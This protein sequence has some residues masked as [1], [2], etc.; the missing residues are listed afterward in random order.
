[1]NKLQ[2]LQFSC[3]KIELYLENN[4]AAGNFRAKSREGKLLKGYLTCPDPRLKI[5]PVKFQGEE[6]EI[7]LSFEGRGPKQKEAVEGILTFISN[8]GEAEISYVIR[9]REVRLESSLGEIR[10]LFHFTNLAR[11]SWEEAVNLFFS[12]EFSELLESARGEEKELYRGLK[13]TGSEQCVEEFLLAI[14]KK[15]PV[16]YHLEKEI[17]TFENME[18]DQKEEIRIDREGWGYTKLR[19]KK[20]GDFLSLEKDVLEESDFLGNSC[21]LPVYF[22]VDRL[23]R[24]KNYGA[25]FLE[26]AYGSMT[27]RIEVNQNQHH[28]MR[29]AIEKRR[30]IK[31]MKVQLTELYV[32]FRAKRIAASR[33]RK[34]TEQILGKMRFTDERNPQGKL[35]MAH[36]YI[37]TDKRL[38]GKWH[39][40]RVG[41]MIQ[42]D[43]DPVAYAYYLYLNTLLN[44][45]VEYQEKVRE[46]VEELYYQNESSWQIAWLML[47]LSREFHGGSIVSSSDTVNSVMKKWDFLLEVFRAGCTSPVLYTEAVM[48]LNFQPTLL[49]ELGSLELRILRFGQSRCMLSEEV[50]GIVQYLSLREKEYSEGLFR[51]LES[52]CLTEDNPEMLQS[53]CSLLIKGNKKENRYFPWYE[54]AVLE[55]LKI[56]RLYEYYM[57]SLDRSKKIDIPRMVLLYFSYE[58]SLSYPNAAYLYRYVHEQRE[59]ME[60]LYLAYAPRIERFMVKQLYS[61]KINRDLGYLYEHLLVPDM[62]TP[63]NASALEKI[64]FIHSFYGKEEADE[65]LIAVH[66]HLKEETRG[67]FYQGRARLPL[68]GKNYLLFRENR[69]GERFLVKEEEHPSAFVDLDSLSKC[70]GTYTCDDLGLALYCCEEKGG[71]QPVREENEEHF[72]FLSEYPEVKEE[73]KQ[74][75]RSRLMDYYEE[76]DRM[77]ELDNWLENCTPDALDRKEREK[78]ID[79]MIARGYYEKAYHFVLVYGPEQV[80]PKSLVRIGTY[81]LEEDTEEK[82]DLLWLMDTAWQKGKYNPALLNFLAEN[83]RGGCRQMAALF[84]AAKEFDGEVY[85]LSERI[86]AQILFSGTNVKEDV[87]IFKAYVAE[88]AKT[89]LE[90]A[91]LTWCA[92][93][94]LADRREMDGYFIRDILRVY[95]RSER[96]HPIT[97]LACLKY[98]A[99]F[100]EEKKPE[101]EE[102]IRDFLW[103]ALRRKEWHFPFL[104]A[105]K[106]YPEM[107]ILSD[108]SILF[109][110]GNADERV[111]LHYREKEAG[112]AAAYLSENMDEL[113]GGLFSREFVL[114][115][116]E[117]LEYYIIAQQENQEQ[118]TQKGILNRK[119]EPL[120]G[121]KSRFGMINQ[122]AEALDRREYAEAEE[123]LEE[124]WR[125]DDLVKKA[126]LSN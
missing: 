92:R 55:G 17:L 32:D 103:E 120:Y 67:E 45:D 65:Y 61:G 123:L 53:L 118:L 108:K 7:H 60:D 15:T 119:E 4:Q 58:T 125:L 87:Q 35:F 3:E 26:H 49:M 6:V 82:E 59:T 47:H 41:R 90:A 93:E 80:N 37:S 106:D 12:P 117:E 34:E 43:K 101:E 27:I 122:M 97:H 29:V 84:Q 68:F 9:P 10:N 51:L 11:S 46:K 40:D 28:R 52:I 86:L 20:E 124:Y 25:V 85:K 21:H 104:Y 74:L 23:H 116:K 88:G 31:Q 79:Q 22:H 102:I 42:E 71:W 24:G 62:L 30:S 77:M 69:W 70:L 56:T 50:K 33:W 91:Y 16:V 2:D 57:L 95:G 14:R 13:S 63:D 81:M 64:M 39:L 36:L 89:P 94:Y 76:A 38:E 72:V 1:M 73:E 8:S 5:D 18:E 107:E 44:E 96:L 115:S 111:V 110:Q 54:R 114:F 105:Y 112:E 113:Y 48:L 66:K 98:F 126:F 83:Y 75:L 99:L 100:P 121:K 78:L 109:Y 19:L